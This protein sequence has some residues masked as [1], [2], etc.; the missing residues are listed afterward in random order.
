MKLDAETLVLAKAITGGGGGGGGG[1]STVTLIDAPT[2]TGSMTYN[3]T[4]QTASFNNYDADKMTVSGDVKATN[5][6]TYMAVFKPNKGYYWDNGD[7][8]GSNEAISVTWSIGKATNTITVSPSSINL[9]NAVPYKDVTVTQTGDGTLSVSSSNT[10]VATVGEISDGMFRVTGGNN[11]SA[12]I[13]VTSPAT[14]NYNAG[15]VSIACNVAFVKI[16]SFSSGTDAEIKAMLDA[17]YADTITWEDM[18]WSVGNTRKIQLNAMSNGW[19]AQDI[20][21][22]I[23]AHD[24]TDLATAINGHTKSCIT[25]QT[26]EVI[27]SSAG[28]AGSIFVTGSNQYNKTFTKWS[29]LY[30]RSFLNSTIF[31]AFPYGSTFKSAIKPSKHYRHTTYNGTEVEQVIDN[32]FLPSYA[33]VFGSG[34]NMYYV[35]TDPTEGTQMTVSKLKYINNNGSKGS[36]TSWWLGSASSYYG[37]SIG[38]C[39]CYVNNSGGFSATQGTFSYGL[40]PAWA[41]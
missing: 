25:V 10:S 17:Y 26:R 22:Q 41:M 20:V 7:G 35:E 15:T 9:G 34:S 13:T 29:N 6:G 39:W 36:A 38:Y 21:V 18:G 28:N 16:V 5:A 14:D 32:L 12:T 31:N 27:S 40:A 3:G 19:A 8:T 1:G 30:M 37:S 23:I 2:Y 4:E 33:E 24:H 11:G